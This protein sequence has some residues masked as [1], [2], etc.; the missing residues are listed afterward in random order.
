MTARPG[1]FQPSFNAG[2]LQPEAHGRTDIKSYYSGAS[3]MLNVEPVPQGGFRLMPRSRRLGRV[4]RQLAIVTGGSLSITGAT[5]S[6]PGVIATLTLPG[7]RAVSVVSLVGLTADQVIAPGGMLVEWSDGTTWRSFASAFG[8][9]TTARARYAARAP[10]DVVTASALRLSLTATPPATTSF[11]LS[12]IVPLAEGAPSSTVR[13]RPFTFDTTTSQTYVA[14]FTDS[15]VDFWRNGAFVGAAATALTGGAIDEIDVTQRFDTMVLLHEDMETARIT[16]SGSDAQWFLDRWP[17]ASTPQVDLGGAYTKIPDIWQIYMQWKTAGTPTPPFASGAGLTLSV[18]VDGEEA[19]PVA[20]PAGPDWV[21]FSALLKAA[22]EGLAGVETG[23]IVN[24]AAA[25]GFANVAISFNGGNLGNRFTVTARVVN[26][27][28]AAATT[29]HVQFGSPGGE[30]LFSA[31]RGWPAAATWYQD[32]FI[33]AGFKSKKGAILASATAAYFDNNTDVQAAT[34]AILANLDTDGAERIVRLARSRHLVIFTTDAEYFVSDRA[35]S[36]TAVPNIVQS[37]RNG[38]ARTVPVVENEG[39]LLYVSRKRALVYNAVFSDV[40]AGYV[41]TPISLLASHIVRDISDAA[42]Q[43]TS[44]TTDA[45]RH[46]M[47]RDDGTMVVGIMIRNQDVTAYARWQ[48]AGQVKAVTVDGLNVVHIAVAR[49]VG[50]ATE[51]FFERLEANLIFD[52]V[53]EQTFAPAT[54]TVTGLADHEGAAVWALADGY[55]EGPFTVAG[56]AITLS[57]ASG[58]V[59]VGRWTAPSVKTLPIPNDVA[60]RIALKRPKRVHTIKAELIGTTSFAVGANGRSARP[61]TLTRVG[62]QIDTPPPAFS[63]LVN[64]TGI[65][66]FSVAGMTELTQTSPGMLQVRDVVIE[67]RI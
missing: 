15:H 12:T 27:G 49:T 46:F 5:L 44:D 20:V 48:T 4:R 40:D 52:S 8:A 65:A 54:A 50:A 13:M 21:A 6:T 37:S 56:G 63:G 55:V 67:A 3:L 51:L 64:V 43:R 32:R 29:A 59:L 42:L 2:E 33:T 22:I 28:D 1:R 58:R 30:N 18:T 60:D 31:A 61:V 53:I 38:V 39:A 35:L 36:R 11:N 17:Y 7:P 47:P 41:S 62:D 45:A 9:D 16:R 25:V 23:V 19:S 26:T 10:G 34:G 66:G 57:K 24:T 14:V